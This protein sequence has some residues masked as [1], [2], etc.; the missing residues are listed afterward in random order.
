[1]TLLQGTLE[2]VSAGNGI[3][4]AIPFIFLFYAC[5]VPLAES[6]ANENNF[7]LLFL[8]CCTKKM[9]VKC[10]A[11]NYI[12]KGMRIAGKTSKHQKSFS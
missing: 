4:A 7:F 8:N 9:L 10:D 6:S 11:M 5:Y 12:I 3:S 2:I 1:M